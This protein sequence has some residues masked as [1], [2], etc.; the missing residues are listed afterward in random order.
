MARTARLV[1]GGPG[2]AAV[3]V[4]AGGAG[5]TLFVASLSLDLVAFALT[6]PLALDARL[7]ILANLYPFVGTEFGP[8]AGGLLVG[9]A[10]LFG[11]DVAM[12]TYHVREHGL[13]ASK[14]LMPLSFAAILGGIC[15]LIGTSTNLVIHG[16]LQSH[17]MEG[18][19]FFELA[20]VGVPCALAGWAYLVFVAPAL[21]PE[22]GLGEGGPEGEEHSALDL[23]AD[24]VRV[25]GEAVPA[26]RTDL[27]F[28][29]GSDRSARL[30]EHV[31][32]LHLSRGEVRSFEGPRSF[33]V[34]RAERV[35]RAAVP[36][37]D[38]RRPGR[39]EPRGPLYRDLVEVEHEERREQHQRGHHRDP[40]AVVLAA[41]G[42]RHAGED[43]DEGGLLL[44]RVLLVEAHGQEQEGRLVQV[45]ACKLRLQ[46]VP[47]RVPVR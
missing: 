44:L 30:P 16:L 10:A 32:L 19:G 8:L 37:L 26:T 39:R 11:V 22:L 23:S 40:V 6:G 29:A 45:S 28:V 15:T 35:E 34:A 31:V 36:P 27:P 1:L 41:P 13:S 20:W 38:D 4:L 46:G 12:L 17:G 25:D 5:L 43:G 47:E 42:E 14:L 3:A 24:P 33:A 21:L 18:L 2:Y 7:T 9:V